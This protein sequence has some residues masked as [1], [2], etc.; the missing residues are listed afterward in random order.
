MV[1]DLSSF[2]LGAVVGVVVGLALGLYEGERSRRLDAQRREGV[3]PVDRTEPAAVTPPA[4]LPSAPSALTAEMQSARDRY[5]AECVAE[6]FD[7]EEAADDFDRM[8][9]S[10]SSDQIAVARSPRR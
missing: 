8:L 4:G 2:A 3:L 1:L 5:V 9:T 6:G 7:P 10:A